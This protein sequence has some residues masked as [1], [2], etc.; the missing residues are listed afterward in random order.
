MSFF[1]QLYQCYICD[2]AS[3]KARMVRA[4][5]AD[6]INENIDYDG[7]RQEFHKHVFPDEAGKPNQ[8]ILV[9]P[10]FLKKRK[11]TKGIKGRA[12]LLHALSHIEFNAINLS[13]DMVGRFAHQIDISQEFSI[14]WEFTGDWLKIADD[15]AKHFLMLDNRLRE[16]GCFY[17]AMPAHD[18]LWQVAIATKDDYLARLAIVP[19]VLEARGLDV[20]PEMIQ[21]FADVDDKTSADLLQIIHDDEITHVAIGK[22]YFDRECQKQ[23]IIDQ[24]TCWRDLVNQYFHG[25]LKAPFNIESRERADF[26][27]EYYEYA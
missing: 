20:V 15:E 7:E 23:G 16:L 11:I 17:G 22:K 1:Q 25:G 6:F 13:L 14:N 3:D 2:N 9:A 8:P 10:K 5:Y 19:L 12:A 18:G 26:A 4:L 27:R 24:V 21:K